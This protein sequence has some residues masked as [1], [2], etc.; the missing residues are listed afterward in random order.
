MTAKIRASKVTHPSRLFSSYLWFVL[1]FSLFSAFI[2]CHK[3]SLTSAELRAITHEMVAAAQRVVGQKS[4][5]IVR[6][7]MVNVPEGEAPAQLSTDH[8]YITISDAAQKSEIEGALDSVAKRHGLARSS[9][10]SVAGIIRF[11]YLRDGQ[12]THA[13]HIVTPVAARPHPPAQNHGSNGPRLA[14]ILDDLGSDRSAADALFALPFPL[15]ISVLPGHPFSAQVA[16]EAYRRGDQVL[17]HLPMESTG[18]ENVEKIELRPGM[19]ADEITKILAGM[20]ETVPHA[21]GVNNHQG[22]R[23]TADPQLMA[24]LMPA[25]RER[26]LFFIDSRT[27]AQT[28]A[29]D[30]AQ[31]DGVRTAYRTTFLDDTRTREAILAQLEKAANQAGKQGWAIAIGHPH[32]TTLAALQEGLPKL[33]ARGIHLVFASDLTH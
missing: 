14:I 28:V 7:E 22:S 33:E 3:R 20:L 12:R 31:R 9:T 24:A 10:S 17:L 18:N 32:H 29:F 11:D 26:G 27:T 4:E 13:I 15:T 1:L 5:V 21:V 30:L 8:I 19:N 6:P 16:E 23:A 25:L 2:G